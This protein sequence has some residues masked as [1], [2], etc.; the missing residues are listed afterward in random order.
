MNTYK[1]IINKLLSK[2]VSISIAE[3]CTGGA[4]SKLFTD[5][6]GISK[7]FEM[8]L[9]TYSNKSK[10]KVLKVSKKT[11]D[12]YGAVSEEVAKLM[13]KNLYKISKSKIC[14]S[15]TGIAGPSGG[16]KSKPIGLVFIGINNNQKN[17]VYKKKFKGSRKQIQNKTIN[18]CL[19]EINK[20]I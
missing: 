12:K 3:S 1:K 8:G 6:P 5:N 20:L 13:S 7:I 9:I 17:I 18:F 4:L 16:S 10:I 14:I 15:T 19:K 2:N 11:I